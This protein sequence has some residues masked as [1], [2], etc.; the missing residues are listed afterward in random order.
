MPSSHLDH[1]LKVCGIDHVVIGS[2]GILD[3]YPDTPEQRKAFQER[4]ASRKKS[5]IAA[6]E[7]DRAPYNFLTIAVWESEEAF[8]NAKAAVALECKQRGYD[9]QETVGS[10]ANCT[11]TKRSN[12]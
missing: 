3:T 1:A 11:T 6:P 4:I 12:D 7:E 8:E 5:G 2:D 9:P 10:G